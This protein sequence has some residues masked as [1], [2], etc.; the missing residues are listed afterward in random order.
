MVLN[1]TNYSMTNT[2]FL[3]KAKIKCPTLQP[4]GIYV[5]SALPIL[6]KCTICNYEWSPRANHLLYGDA[7][8]PICSKKKRTKTTEEFKKQLSIKNP[9]LELLSNYENSLSKV[10]VRC[11][12]CGTENI[13]IAQNLLRQGGCPKCSGKI[14]RTTEEIIKDFKKVHGDL[15]DY[16]K[17]KFKD[18]KEPVEIICKKHGSFMQRPDS[19]LQGCGCKKCF[20]DKE[21]DNTESFIEKAKNIHG[22]FYD[23]SEV[24]YIDSYTPVK[25][26]C[27][28]HGPFMQKP[29]N[30]LGSKT[31]CPV[32]KDSLGERT[33]S[34]FLKE[35]NIKFKSEKSFK[36]LYDKSFK[37]KLRYDFFI[38]KYNLLIEFNGIQH[39]RFS[40][41]WHKNL[42][43][44]HRSLHRDWLKRKYAKDNNFNYLVI[45]YKD[46][47]NISNILKAY[48]K[49]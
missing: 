4:L 21:S 5:K 34:Q 22:D 19:H 48:L 40:N 27:K 41:L 10:K 43:D 25:I 32:C 33:I 1:H 24:K 28:I 18:L 37:N 45:S 15:Y 36:D 9:T 26:I 42:H 14:K 12:V 44:F 16:T 17:V 31:G 23:Y 39:Y 3:E 49:I 6:V 46:L 30:H 29:N 11:T 13:V 2:E 38:E 47:K 20:Y 35:N 8:C 7:H